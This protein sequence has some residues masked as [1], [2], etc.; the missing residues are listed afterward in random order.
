METSDNAVTANS[1]ADIQAYLS[2]FQKDI[3]GMDEMDE[4]NNNILLLL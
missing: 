4:T 1:I 3:Q 2:N